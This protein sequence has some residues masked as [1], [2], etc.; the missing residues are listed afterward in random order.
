MKKVSLFL[1]LS[2]ALVICL[3]S[4]A[5]SNTDY[6]L[7]VISNNGGSGSSPSDTVYLEAYDVI[8]QSIALIQTYGLPWAGNGPVGIALDEKHERVFVTYEFQDSIWAFNAKNFDLLYSVGVPGAN[9]LSGIVIDT[10]HDSL[11]VVERYGSVVYIFNTSTVP[12]TYVGARSITG[13]TTDYGALGLAFDRVQNRLY[14]TEMDWFWDLTTT[15][16]VYDPTAWGSPVTTYNMGG[17]AAGIAVDDSDSPDSVLIYTTS[18]ATGTPALRKYNTSDGS[19]TVLNFD[20]HP[21]GVTVNPVTD[22][23]YVT[24][25]S[26]M[27]KPTSGPSITVIDGA[28]MTPTDTVYLGSGWIPTDLFVGAMKFL[29]TWPVHVPDDTCVY[30]G[31]MAC[32]PVYLDSLPSWDVYSA[33]W[34]LEYDEA[35]LHATHATTE[36]SIAEAW[37]DPT[38]NIGT[39]WIAIGMAG[40]VPLDSAG[41]LVWVCF[42]VVGDIGDTTLLTFRDSLI[43]LNDSTFEAREGIVRVCPEEYM[44]CGRVRYCLNDEP[45]RCAKMILSG[46]EDDTVHAN[47]NGIY[48]FLHLPAGLDYTLKAK[49]VDDFR[50]AITAFDASLVLRYVVSLLDLTPC[51]LIS[52]DV[53]GN[54][55]VN[56]YDA[57]F[58]LK[59]VVHLI[60][61]FP[62]GKDWKFIPDDFPLDTLNWC[63]APDSIFYGNL[64]E[65]WCFED[66]KGILYGDVSGNWDGIPLSAESGSLPDVLSRLAVRELVVNPGEE[67]VVP[68]QVEDI[69]EV[70]AVEL[71]LTYDNSLL[72]LVSVTPGDLL[73]GYYF[74]RNLSYGEIRLAMA[75]ASPIQGSGDLVNLTF[76][77][78]PQAQEGMTTQLEVNRFCLNEISA[79]GLA[80]SISIGSGT[81]THP[82]EFS[83]SQNYPNPFNPETEIGFTVPVA[84]QVQLKIYNVAGQLVKVYQGDYGAGAHS[85]SWDG[86]N[87][88]GENVGS[89]IYFYRMEAGNFVQQKKMVLIR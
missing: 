56:A 54:C 9:D 27:S 75:G 55:W 57:S 32:I 81:T 43:I 29:P 2:V 52:G 25:S 82:M 86:T 30:Q 83:L 10:V 76:K 77:V 59:R 61:Q 47:A 37:G 28:T 51:Q 78:L 72:S 13:F 18:L 7:Y 4:Q 50:G 62:I 34:V 84:C 58:I 33:Q 63:T 21:T 87:M 46:G 85:I 22:L 40:T 24:T 79:G 12:I 88:K 6:T 5:V 42:D 11:Y 1:V 64:S 20:Y 49:K 48:K 67:F 60:P 44:I 31:K 80:F 39:G 41:V 38:Y 74:E 36:N 35:V 3:S 53:T 17:P 23:V 71:N 16:Y 70:Y 19:V 89:G 73:S 8:N 26:Y 66:W 68:I 14:V 15:V 65:D 45:V 69:S